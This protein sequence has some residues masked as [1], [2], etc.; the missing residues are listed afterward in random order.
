[1]KLLLTRGICFLVLFGFIFGAGELV[2]WVTC[3]ALATLSEVNAN[4]YFPFMVTLA[5][6]VSVPL[7]F[8]GVGI[9]RLGTNYLNRESK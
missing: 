3:L 8:S 4:T 5:L 7:L 2:L 9:W 1:M 6:M